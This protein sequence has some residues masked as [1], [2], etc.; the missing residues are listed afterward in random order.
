MLIFDR[1]PSYSTAAMFAAAV[2]KRHGLSAKVYDSQE[3]SNKADP[4]PC[5]LQPPIVLVERSD[6]D[7]EGVINLAATF[8]GEFAGT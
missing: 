6:D 1:F 8:G 4:F 2:Q 5:E 3:A 7:E